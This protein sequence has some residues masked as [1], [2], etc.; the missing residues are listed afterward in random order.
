VYIVLLF[1]GLG[2]YWTTLSIPD[3]GTEEKE[4]GNKVD[5]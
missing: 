1:M 5:C 3:E 2:A 4:G